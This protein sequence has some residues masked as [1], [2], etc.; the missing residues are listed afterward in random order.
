M[1]RKPISAIA[2]ACLA[3]VLATAPAATQAQDWTGQ[4]TLYGWGA[5]IGGDFTPL[6]GAPT[7]S[8]EKSLSE[9]LEDLDTAFFATAFARRGN[10]VL[11]GDLTY[12]AA[13]K[14]G[15]VPPGIPASGEVTLRALT[16]A[17]GR[18]F[19]AG[20]GTTVDVMGGVRGWSV[21]GRVSVPLAGV[22]IAPEQTFV[23]PV[24]ALR[25]NT[26]LSNR[27]SVLTYADLGGFGVGSDFTWQAAVTASY[28]VTEN[29]YLSLGYRHL[30]V[31]YADGGT[32]FEG[33]MSGP[34]IGATWRF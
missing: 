28:A 26:P 20:G 19:D 9:V 8:F 15:L 25:V 22:S 12:S 13:S 30:F 1:E 21:D 32:V 33:A 18:R 6:T 5:G 27:W 4:V 14:G 7:L 16:L 3:A 17:A 31:D 24:L 11:F 34:V 29:L 2:G 10:F 23:D